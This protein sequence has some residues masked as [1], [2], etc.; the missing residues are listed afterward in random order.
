MKKK[1][2]GDLQQ[3]QTLFAKRKYSQVISLL[4]P[5]IFLYRKEMA[6]HRLLGYACFYSGDFGGAYSYFQRARDLQPD[7]IDTLLGLALVMIRRR[8]TTDALRIWL[9]ILDVEPENSRAQKALKMAKLLEEDEWLE[10]IEN[11]KYQG[12]LPRHP[13]SFR[14]LTILSIFIAVA[15]IIAAAFYGLYRYGLPDVAYRSGQ[16]LLEIH[17]EDYSQGDYSRFATIILSDREL[18]QELGKL[19]RLFRQYR[20]NAVRYQG[21]R[22]LMSNAPL[23]VKD[24]VSLLIGQLS[25]PDFTNFQDGYS[26]QDIEADPH[27]FQGVYVRWKGRVANVVT[28]EQEIH[29]D[30]LV[31]YEDGRI[32]EGRVP[33][34]LDFAANLQGGEAVELIAQVNISEQDEIQLSG[35]SL[36]R[37]RSE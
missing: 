29:F 37:I 31:G 16:E 32:L 30:F 33:V 26:I 12:F 36:R 25:E 13:R 10:L 34:V 11:K 5:Q 21:N 35:S 19:E 6:F 20:D 15:A 22:L 3:A 24:R 17:P 23:E 18:E 27:L 1:H 2:S 4:S 7:D 14:W 28:T 9:E 8:K